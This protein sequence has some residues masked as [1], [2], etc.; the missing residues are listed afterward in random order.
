VLHTLHSENAA[1]DDI[2]SVVCTA[3][4]FGFPLFTSFISLVLDS[5][6][7]ELSRAAGRE[8]FALGSSASVSSPGV[9]S[10]VLSSSSNGVDVPRKRS[11]RGFFRGSILGGCGG[12]DGGVD[13]GCGSSLFGLEVTVDDVGTGLKKFKIDPFLIGSVVGLFVVVDSGVFFAS[14][15]A[16]F[17][18]AVPIPLDAGDSESVTSDDTR[19][20]FVFGSFGESSRMLRLP[21]VRNGLTRD[22]GTDGA[23]LAHLTGSVYF[24]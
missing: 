18:G 17:S 5:R 10:P 3:G 15:L 7:K 8:V 24:Q 2:F 16:L 23:G 22:R 19:R 11:K 14:S 4:V 12:E 20:F 9:S 13:S 6:C 1:C 21:Y